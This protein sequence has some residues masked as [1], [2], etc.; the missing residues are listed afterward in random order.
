M[1][2]KYRIFHVFIAIILGITG[3]LALVFLQLFGKEPER[4]P[5]YIPVAAERVAEINILQLAEDE[6]YTLLF[7]AKD[8]GFYNNLKTIADQRIEKQQEYGNLAIDFTQPILFFSAEQNGIPYTGF[9]VSLTEPSDFKKNIRKYL[10]TQQAAAV[11]E[12][13]ALIL[14]DPLGKV[15]QKEV[16][17]AANNLLKNSKKTTYKMPGEGTILR[18][19]DKHS[20]H[21]VNVF[22]RDEMI[23]IKGEW[24]V[25]EQAEI[26]PYSL[27]NKGLLIR[28]NGIPASFTDTLSKLIPGGKSVRM[29]RVTAMVADYQGMFIGSDEKGTMIPQPKMNLILRLDSAFSVEK[30]LQS[31]PEKLRGHNQLLL[32]ESTYQIKQLD[33]KTLFIGL[34]EKA[35]VKQ[36]PSSVLVEIKGPLQPLFDIKGTGMLVS[37][38][39]VI[40]A[41]GAGKVY[42]SK[43]KNVHLTVKQKG[44]K[45]VIDGEMRFKEGAFALHETL[46]LALMV[47]PM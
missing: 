7:K 44:R 8:E 27:K 10:Q 21:P 40:P 14:S 4:Q 28:I 42:T 37:F 33:E 9:L 32:G 3:I 34:D 30:L 47:N 38:I 22:H 15:S 24:T 18:F 11:R 19:H 12:H 17:L 43:V 29:P 41:V 16:Q 39:D 45:A 6:V 26:L 25:D 5:V 13:T 1:Q 2:V 36:A 31:V 35:L 46:K 20:S 23:G